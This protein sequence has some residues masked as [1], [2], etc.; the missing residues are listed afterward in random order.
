[1]QA[2][3]FSCIELHIYNPASKKFR[4]PKIIPLIFLNFIKVLFWKIEK[5]LMKNVLE[6][7]N[8]AGFR[9]WFVHRFNIK[10][11]PVLFLHLSKHCT[12]TV[13]FEFTDAVIY[14]AIGVGVV[15]WAQTE[16][17]LFQTRKFICIYSWNEESSSGSWIPV[18]RGW[19][20]NSSFP[21]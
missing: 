13:D 1:M 11:T 8:Y 17:Q 9:E 12:I 4:K 14:S 19:L 5:T 16:L 21:S 7:K 18:C 15:N 6:R 2:Q 3:N 20:G 10:V